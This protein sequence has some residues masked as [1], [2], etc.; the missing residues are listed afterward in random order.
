M[1]VMGRVRY[2]KLSNEHKL[3]GRSMKAIFDA[4]MGAVRWFADEK[5]YKFRG[6]KFGLEAYLNAA[7]WHFADLPRDEQERILRT[8]LPRIESY[9]VI[10]DVETS[11][12]VPPTEGETKPTSGPARRKVTGKIE[13]D[14][15]DD[16]PKKGRGK[17]GNRN[18]G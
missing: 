18:S 10:P 15:P 14:L 16:P 17:R 2:Q 7:L 9:L 4:V 6:R 3:G 8:Y 5:R 12:A 11:E 13:V 1:R